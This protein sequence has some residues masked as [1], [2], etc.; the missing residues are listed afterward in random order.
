MKKRH[1]FHLGILCLLFSFSNGINANSNLKLA[2]SPTILEW[3]NNGTVL[4][5]QGLTTTP[6]EAFFPNQ[7]EGSLVTITIYSSSGELLYQ[8][9]TYEKD[10]DYAS[11][12]LPEGEKT[13]VIQIGNDSLTFVF[14]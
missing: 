4:I 11:L 12:N 8:E 7:R 2:A 1:F 9:S 3:F 10:L 13:L 6:I 5:V 14:E